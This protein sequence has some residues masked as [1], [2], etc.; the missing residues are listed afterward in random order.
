VIVS[1]FVYFAV[2]W[3]RQRIELWHTMSARWRTALQLF[4]T[5]V[6]EVMGGAGA[7]WG[8]SEIAGPAGYSLRLGW[9]DTH[10]GQP[11]FD[12]WRI[13]CA[14]VFGL[15]LVRWARTQLMQLRKPQPPSDTH[16]ATGS[17]AI[18]LELTEK[19]KC[20]EN[21]ASPRVASV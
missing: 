4:S 7:V 8:A 20:A 18:S 16:T 17:G 5:F 10:F 1:F 14:V 13:W 15:C 6:L 19:G 2:W 11:S 21:E 9:G 12:F 3:S